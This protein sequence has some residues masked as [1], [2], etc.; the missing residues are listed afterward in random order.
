MF[1]IEKIANKNLT[2]LYV[3]DCSD[4]RKRTGSIFQTMFEK[5]IFASNGEDGFDKFKKNKIDIIFTDIVM[6]KLNGIDMIKKIRELD[7]DIYIVALSAHNN[8][9]YLTQS[10]NYQIQGYLLNLLIENSLERV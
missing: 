4:S 3:E 10:I 8:I 1:L 2:L 5:V 7:R 6:P 9:K